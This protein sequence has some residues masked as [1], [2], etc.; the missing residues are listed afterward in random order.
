MTAPYAC[1]LCGAALTE[2]GAVDAYCYGCGKHICPACGADELELLFWGHQ[3]ADHFDGG[4][5]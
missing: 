5:S 1:Y 4:E 2:D 3:P